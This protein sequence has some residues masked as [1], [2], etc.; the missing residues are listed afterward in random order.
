MVN[1]EVTAFLG[2]TNTGKTYHAMEKLFSHS[3]GVIGFPLR[4]LARENFEIA[5][6][7]L[8]KNEVALIT[9][10]EKIIPE[11]AKYFFCTV[12][13]IPMDKEFDF[14]AIDEI[15]LAADFERGHLF[16]EKILNKQGKKET[17]FLGSR[18]IENVLKKIFPEIKIIRRQRLSKLSYSGYKNLSRL[19]KRSAIIAFSQ[20]DLY[21][22][23]E[24]IKQF[25]GGVSVVMGALSPNVRNAQV[26]LFEDG[27]V[28]YMVATDAIG[29]GLNLNIKNIFFTNL[30]KFDG[31]KRR[32]LTYD[33]IAQISGRA[34][35]FTED[36]FF[37][38]TFKLK[39]LNNN[40]IK[41]IEDLEYT[42]I[43]KIYWRNTKIDFQSPT[44]LIKSLNQNPKN[45]IFLQK[46]NAKDF[47][48]LK[49]I[50]NDKKVCQKINLEKNLMLLWE[51]CS[52]PDFT[53]ILDDFHSRFLIRIF[54]FL[55][56][57][58]KISELW[59]EEQLTKIKKKS[60][61]IGDL[62]L[63]IAQIRI[64]SFISYKSNW[65]N[66]PIMYQKRIRKIEYDLSKYLHE[67]LINQF[68]SDYNYFKSK[69]HILN[70][71]IQNLIFIDDKKIKFG[72]STIGEIK[73]FSFSVK[74]S[75]KN[76][77]NFNFKVLKK[78]LEFFANDLVSD[79]ESSSYN[80]FSF[81]IS[82][83]IFW[84]DQIVAK[85]YK[86]Q[87]IFKPRIKIFFDSFFQIFK[88]KIEQRMFNYF[89]FVLK[90]TLPFHKFIDRFDERPTMIRAILFFLKE[91]IGQCKK[92]EIN[93]FYD[94][95]KSDQAKWLKN[96]GIKNGVHFLFFKKCKFNFF[97]Q[98][99]INV[100]YILNLNNFISYEIIK[101]NN[102]KKIK[103][104]MPYYQKMGFYLVKVEQGERY[105]A[106][107]S[108]LERVICKA[109]SLRKNKNKSPRK[110]FMRNDFEKIA[111]T[112]INK[113][114][115]C[116]FTDFN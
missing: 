4:L 54:T 80:D 39:S 90:N 81:D 8:N 17:I 73:G 15:Q 93:N 49:I 6:K 66:K 23:A 91:G 85:F 44:K 113:I 94:S 34:G 48:C 60:P 79:F 57:N 31:K 115:L 98:M 40:L 33:E 21:E 100:Y 22:I 116:N 50:L 46:K 2:P 71:N 64:W 16:T 92:K 75:F 28:D 108:Y 32:Y 101:I 12:E 63:K 14:V 96:I 89:N 9:G 78:R 7:K 70:T 83:N 67:S 38:T 52:I 42:E 87:D 25:Y 30:L 20:I 51:V 18:S 24:K 5:K 56:E 82:G 68:V 58:K 109:Y 13:S 105:L 114:N 88:K 10:E 41:F 37:G 111:F 35:R 29:L 3:N 76:K 99:I 45:R 27:K 26:K 107:F 102:V 53:N 104:H 19:P 65:L 69:Q 97:S 1:R 95:L 55:V 106:H 59:L 84:K 103:D 112:N 72:N 77:K 11:K 86:G 62:N 110:N 61:K 47:N 74:P 36:G 43:K